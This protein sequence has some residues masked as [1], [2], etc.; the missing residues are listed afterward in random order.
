[1]RRSQ[2]ISPRPAAPP[3]E[4]RAA[5]TPAD[6]R[7]RRLVD[8][9]G[10]QRLPAAIRRRFGK[11]LSGGASVAY[12]GVITRMEMSRAGR[13]LALLTRLVGAPL[14]FDPA[15]VGLPAVVVVTEDVAS[16]GQFWIRQY[17][18]QAGFP[19]T[20]HS[21]KRFRGPTGL[22]EHV[23][24]GIGMTLRL[25]ATPGALFFLS[26]RYFLD[27]AG[28]RLWLPHRLRPGDLIVGHRE[29]GQDRFAFTL[30]LTHPL[31]GTLIS[32]EAVFRDG[33]IFN[34]GQDGP[35][36]LLAS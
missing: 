26:E 24:Y 22:E 8:E 27:L 2:E 34:G 12:Q 14:P 33:E 16:E 35:S 5:K 18:R 1:M 25:E 15:S 6:P 20:V 30:D 21:S 32:Q 28:L 4:A 10:W 36:P 3:L 29:L 23:G 19:Q 17:G 11:R 31:L 7:F 13:A 9:A